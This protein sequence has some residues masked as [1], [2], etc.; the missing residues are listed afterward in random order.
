LV[1]S[2]HEVVDTDAEDD[3]EP[4]T[5]FLHEWAAQF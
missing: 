3:G 2:A 1:G 5:F 4:E